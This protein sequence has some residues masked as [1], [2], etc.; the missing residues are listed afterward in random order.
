[1][2]LKTCKDLMK[3]YY[4]VLVYSVIALTIVLDD[5]LLA[6]YKKRKSNAYFD[7]YFEG[8]STKLTKNFFN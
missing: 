4:D 7:G 1:M 3:S 8:L 6:E 5:D 2:I